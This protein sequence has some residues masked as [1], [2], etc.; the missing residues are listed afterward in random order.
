MPETRNN[1][2]RVELRSPD[3]SANPY[4]ALAA[5]LAAGLD[6]IRRQMTPPPKAEANLFA[7]SEDEIAVRGISRLP[8]NLGDAL[9]ALEEDDLLR[10]MLGGF[11]FPRYVQAK[12]AEWEAY[13]AQVTAWEVDEYLNEL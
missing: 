6:G 13:C 1:N 9:R 2:I 3:A 12:K 10:G 11:A 7:M 5:C 4:L 8:E